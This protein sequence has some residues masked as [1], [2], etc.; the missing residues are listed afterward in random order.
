MNFSKLQ[1][2]GWSNYFLQ[3]LA[4]NTDLAAFE[5]LAVF[6]IIAIHRS[7]IEAIGENGTAYERKENDWRNDV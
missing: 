4:Q 5:E 6:R 7:R 2:L 3:Q 1:P